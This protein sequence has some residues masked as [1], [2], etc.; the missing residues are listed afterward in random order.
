MRAGHF[1]WITSTK[2]QLLRP[3][4]FHAKNS[5]ALDDISVRFSKLDNAHYDSIV[6]LLC[7]WVSTCLPA[8]LPI[9]LSTC[10]SVCLSICLPA[11]L[12][13]SCSSG[14]TMVRNLKRINGEIKVA[15]FCLQFKPIVSP[16]SAGFSPEDNELYGGFVWM[17]NSG[18]SFGH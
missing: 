3:T 9:C 14:T 6:F 5:F 7:I 16:F 4:L 2:C 13:R 1:Q 12:L 17:M 8:G 18:S 11:C 10:L 15:R